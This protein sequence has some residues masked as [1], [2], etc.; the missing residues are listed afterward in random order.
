MTQRAF[1]FLF[2]LFSGKVVA[3]PNLLQT[4]SHS[5]VRHIHSP[6]PILHCVSQPTTHNLSTEPFLVYISQP[7]ALHAL[8]ETILKIPAAAR[9]IHF[10]NLPLHCFP[11]HTASQPHSK[12][13][14]KLLLKLRFCR[15]PL[16]QYPFYC[17]LTVWR[18]FKLKFCTGGHRRRLLA[19]SQTPDLRAAGQLGAA[20]SAVRP[21][22]LRGDAMETARGTV[23]QFCAGGRPVQF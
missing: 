14:C 4:T 21:T 3:C 1:I 16:H 20:A 2:Q 13:F 10:Q 6:R 7:T 17:L 5:P 12:T 18:M 23:L 8:S 19:G 15:R 11:H 22:C 9:Q